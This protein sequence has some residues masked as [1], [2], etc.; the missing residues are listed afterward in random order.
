MTDNDLKSTIKDMEEKLRTYQ[1]KLMELMKEQEAEIEPSKNR[2]TELNNL[3]PA[4]ITR[5]QTI[6][7]SIKHLAPKKDSAEQE[8]NRKELVKLTSKL[9]SQATKFKKDTQLDAWWTYF[10]DFC[11]RKHLVDYERVALL[12]DLVIDHPHGTLWYQNNIQLKEEEITFAA[13]KDAFYTQF[14]SNSWKTE[15]LQDLMDIVYRSKETARSFCDR[16]AVCVRAVEI[17]WNM[18]TPEHLFIKAVP[19]YKCPPS[20]QRMLPDQDLTKYKTCQVVAE[21]LANFPGVPTD[22]MRREF[23]CPVCPKKITWSCA[24]GQRSGNKRTLAETAAESD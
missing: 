21:L 20:V 24:C 7:D 14:L 18:D 3:I 12:H 15:R 8:I 13:L 17:P 2:M 16:F 1:S 10:S 4:L 9:S 6:K 23:T 11:S 5:I 19:F 22:V